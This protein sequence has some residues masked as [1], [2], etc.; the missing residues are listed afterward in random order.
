VKIALLSHP[1]A[2][3]GV[4]VA[5][6]L[7]AR[8]VTPALLVLELPPQARGLGRSARR[9]RDALTGGTATPM[10]DYARQHGLPVIAGER[11][12]DPGLLDALRAKGIDLFI[13]AGAGILRAP[14]LAVAR[15]GTLNAHMGLL[16]AYRGMNVAE[17]AAL[18]RAPVGCTVHLIDPGIDTGAIIATRVVDIN[19]VRSIDELR[20]RV[21]AAQLALLADT[22]S[23]IVSAGGLPPTVQQRPEDGK[24]YFRMHP[25]LRALLEERLRTGAA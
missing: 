9:V 13:H 3:K 25:E 23:A 4:A 12:T 22:T 17:W 6:A 21:D 18:E 24:Q 15:L 8:G 1:A 14:L 5:K 11:L 7:A 10:A 16:P 2:N 19:G 20:A